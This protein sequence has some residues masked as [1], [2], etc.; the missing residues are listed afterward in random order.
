MPNIGDMAP[1]FEMLSDEGKPVKLS[2]YRG[3][4]VILYFYPQDFTSGCELQACNF[5]DNYATVQANNAVVLGVSADDVESHKKFREALNLPFHLLV[6]ANGAVAQA[7]SS[8]GKR[9]YSDGREFMGV[10]RSHW[11][12]DENGKIV[13]IQ[14]PVKATESVAL[15]LQ[16]LQ[17]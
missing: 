13:D 1:D 6:D 12:I 8:Y 16:K 9:T 10:L 15:A 5:R 2:D 4:K 7:W 3:K 17:G 14:N 11:I